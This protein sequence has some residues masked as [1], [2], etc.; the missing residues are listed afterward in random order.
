MKNILLAVAILFAVPVFGQ[1]SPPPPIPDPQRGLVLVPQCGFGSTPCPPKDAGGYVKPVATPP[2]TIYTPEK[3]K[4]VVPFNGTFHIATPAK[5]ETYVAPAPILSTPQS[6]PSP[7][8]RPQSFDG[9]G[10]TQ[11]GPLNRAI[12]KHLAERKAAKIDKLQQQA[13]Q[14]WA[15]STEKQK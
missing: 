11:Y 14:D 6:Q 5:G 10:T 3:P 9:S 2:Q 1:S 7:A 8:S 4:P 13:A 12:R 15:T